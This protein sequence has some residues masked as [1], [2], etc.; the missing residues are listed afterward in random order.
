MLFCTA[1]FLIFGQKRRNPGQS[2]SMRKLPLAS[3]WG[4]ISPEEENFAPE[5]LLHS[6]PNCIVGPIKYVTRQT[7]LLYFDLNRC[8][9]EI[10]ISVI[11][12]TLM[13]E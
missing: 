2:E 6:F 12:A 3:V 1:C 4:E 8:N 13:R 10:E 9:L 7:L 11:L 5:S